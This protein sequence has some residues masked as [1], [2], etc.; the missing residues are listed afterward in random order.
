MR[1]LVLIS[2]ICLSSGCTRAFYRLRADRDTYSAIDERDHDPRWDLPRISVDTPPQSRLHDPFNPDHPPMPPDDLAAHRYMHWANGMHGYRHWHKDGDAPWIEDPS[3]LGSLDLAENGVLRLTPDQAVAIG[4]L[5]S[6][7]YQSQIES[8]Y[9]TGLAL[10]LNRYD[11]Y[12]HWFGTNNTTWT[13]FGSKSDE[14]NL[15]TVTNSAGFT[16][17]FPAGAQLLV[18]FLNSFMFQFAGP[19]QMSVTSNIAVQLIQPILRGAGRDVRMEGLTQGERNL[20]YAVRTFAHFRKQFS[21][22]VIT[23]NY[24]QLL[25]QEQTIRNTRANLVSQEQN[26]RLHEA[27]YA[28]GTVSTVQVDQVFQSLESA[29]LS[30]LQSETSLENQRDAYKFQLGLPAY[31]PIQ[32]DDSQLAP[33]QL[34]DPALTGLQDELE[35]FLA[36]Y[37]ELDA[38][39]P[40]AKLV[41]GYGKLTAYQRRGVKVA[42]LIRGELERWKGQ[43]DRAPKEGDAELLNRERKAFQ[44]LT[45]QLGDVEKELA[46]IEQEIKKDRPKVSE[47]TRTDNWYTLQTRTRQLI[48]AAG[49]LFVIQ[50]QIRVYLI[51]LE[52]VNFEE[53]SATEEALENRLDLMNQRA[54]VVD[55]WRQIWVTA[56]A[57]EAGLNLLFNMTL[58][59]TPRS[60]DKPL[61]ANPVDFRA[62]ANT[63][64]VGFNID[65]P[66]NRYAEQNAYRA[67]LINYQSVRRSYMALEDQIRIAIRTDLRQLRL[68]RLNFE[69]QRQILISAA[70]QLEAERD[71][72][73]VIENAADTNNTQNILN[74][75]NSLL[76]AQNGLIGSWVSYK[77]DRYRLLLDMERLQVDPQG[78]YIDEYDNQPAKSAQRDNP[79]LLPFPTP[80]QQNR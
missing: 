45:G 77:T 61:S 47:T 53:E 11:F 66:L 6:R 5:D 7:E 15:L 46:L 42:E 73:L 75:L 24:L 19:D 1:L 37:R 17:N 69:I 52:P 3:W 12:V 25:L 74:A 58:S 48:A 49:Q 67:S 31:I 28:A 57:L 65:T 60:V 56:N 50:T 72:L 70:R 9:L 8:L 10:T 80:V 20:L 59:N 71:R 55:S 27:L 30:L 4:L 23:Q 39:P 51:Q 35:K 64:T 22:N 54:A 44:A 43:I 63:Y 41:E 13:H 68:D 29:R 62:F 76:S 14:S 38:P 16:K 18:D 32:L 40:V 78:R 33:F 2:L 21:F 36:G 79:T 26:L 34:A